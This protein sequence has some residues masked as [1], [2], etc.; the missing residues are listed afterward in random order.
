V[1]NA[2]P[3]RGVD[4]PP[5][6]R[7]REFVC[8][9]IAAVSLLGLV[10]TYVI[11]VRTA[12]GQA[13]DL[14]ALR[15]AS[16]QVRPVFRVARGVLGTI[17]VASLAVVFAVLFGVALIQGK[18]RLAFVVGAMVFAS[19]GTT[20][21]LK[22]VLLTRPP[23][24]QLSTGETSVNTLPSGHSTIAMIF[25]VAMLFVVPRKWQGAVALIGA[26]FA[27]AVG[28]STVIQHWHRPSDVIAAW[29]VVATFSFSTLIVLGRVDALPTQDEAA[30][31][32][33]VTPVLLVAMFATV[34]ALAAATLV[35]FGVHVR[36]GLVDGG[37]FRSAAAFGFSAAAITAL[38][39]TVVAS[40]L[41]V[42]RRPNR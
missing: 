7:D 10:A 24:A 4:T 27:V 35:G 26:P 19:V 17:S 3:F 1:V 14:T 28:I 5:L 29:F 8:G 25:V 33:Q 2:E 20:E 36:R 34:T 21:L 37:S 38:G 9:C 6:L 30:R 42:L 41:W 23:L 15:G 11:A 31:E 13:L 16:I 22:R 18:R 40:I 12:R 32:R 39:F